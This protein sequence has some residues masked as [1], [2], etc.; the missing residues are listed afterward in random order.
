MDLKN[1]PSKDML[2]S[3][4]LVSSIKSVVTYI[5][6]FDFMDQLNNKIYT[7]FGW[8]LMKQQYLNL[9]Q[10]IIELFEYI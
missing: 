6:M 4:T 3:R 9:L 10:C 5:S 1:R 8:I 7:F 2:I